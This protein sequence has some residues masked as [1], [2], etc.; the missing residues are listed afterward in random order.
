MLTLADLKP[1]IVDIE[2][3]FTETQKLIVPLR[4]PSWV[5]WN[6]L[7]MEVP[8]PEP[9]MVTEFKDGKK[10]YVKESGAAYEHKVQAANNRRV[11]RRVTLALIEAGNLPELKH[12]PVTEQ[13]AAVESMDSGIFQAIVRALNVLVNTTMGRVN[14]TRF[15]DGQLSTVSDDDMSETTLDNRIMAAITSNGKTFVD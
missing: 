14:E 10:V 12:A 7:G 4:V 11:L 13:L 6:E 2:I 15:R 8:H 5:E 1:R 9:E 3:T